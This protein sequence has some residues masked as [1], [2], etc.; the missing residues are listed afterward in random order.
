MAIKLLDTDGYIEI[1][2]NGE[3]WFLSVHISRG[4][5]VK[6]KTILEGNK[7]DVLRE[8]TIQSDIWMMP[9][10]ITENTW[11]EIYKSIH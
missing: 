9:L 7:E 4:D 2:Y 1:Y 8:A 3:N 11:T 10:F 5:S 6:H